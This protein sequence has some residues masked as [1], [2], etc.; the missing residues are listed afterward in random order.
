[1]DTEQLIILVQERPAIYDHRRKDHKNRDLIKVLWQEIAAQLQFPGRGLR[2]LNYHLPFLKYG[3]F[4]NVPRFKVKNFL[5][6][7][8]IFS[9]Y[10]FFCFCS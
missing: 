10:L 4:K 2:I 1:M 5:I 6:L 3:K 7:C 9:D 8:L